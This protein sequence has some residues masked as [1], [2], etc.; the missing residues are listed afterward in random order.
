MKLIQKSCIDCHDEDVQ[1]GNIR[2]DNLAS[3]KN[4][5]HS[6][7]TWLDVYDKVS[8]GEMPPKKKAF[9]EEEKKAFLDILGPELSEFDKEKKN[10]DG[11]VVLRRLSAAEYENSIKDLLH[12][13]HLEVKPYLPADAEY[14]GIENVAERQ[15]IAYSHIAMYLKAAETSLQAAVGLRNKPKVRPR[16]FPGSKL[17]AA[18]KAFNNAYKAIGEKLILI[19]EP[20]LAQ[21]SWSLFRSPPE[22][23]FYKIRIKAHSAQ[24][25]QA[26]F[27]T[28]AKAKVLPGK[29]KQTV[30][31]GISLG[32]FLK[33]FDLH[34][35]SKVQEATVW[36]NGSERLSIQCEDLPLRI[37]KFTNG[38]KPG[39]WDAVA[40]DWV[41]IEGPIISQWPS[42]GHKT[43]FGDLP[44]K[45]WTPQS[46]LQRPRDIAIGTG[47]ERR[48]SSVNNHV[49]SKDPL[50]D[51]YPLLHSFMEKAYRRKVA[52]EEVKTMQKRVL[53]AIEQ[54]ICFH[55]AM[56]IAYKAI[57]CTPDFLYVR[58]S[59]GKLNS[60][61]LATRLSLFLWRSI[62]DKQL[63]ETARSG[64][65]E[66]QNTLMAEAK[67]MLDDP[68][69]DRF[70]NDFLNQW[71][72]MDSIYSTVPDK[73]LYPEYHEQNLLIE[74]LVEE[75]RLYFREM[76]KKNL[77]IKNVV[78]SDFSFLNDRLARHYKIPGV[79]GSKFRKVTL[80]ENSVRGGIIT[81]G[82]M[83]KITA[84]GFTTSPIKRGIWILENVLG[85]PPPPPPPNAGSIEPDT[86][87]AK[88]IREQLDKHRE[89]KS[90]ANCHKLIDPPGFALECFDIMGAFRKDYRSMKVGKKRIIDNGMVRYHI[91]LGLPV[92][93]SGEFSG[94]TFS[95]IHSFKKL[96]LKDTRQIARNLV[97]RLVT[98]STG[99]VP[100]FSDRKI[101]NKLLDASEKDGFKLKS[102]I[103]RVLTTPMFLEK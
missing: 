31:I 15:Q 28:S 56:L 44:I 43:L 36:L 32:R 13:P 12:I 16:R 99:A 78:D 35:E 64:K 96:L 77:S 57:L 50:T 58:E 9:S 45:K 30:A 54:K 5:P 55:D 10:S 41:E 52:D 26:G 22:P 100:T 60:N 83:M 11:R 82:S 70:I 39:I 94:E 40:I 98:Q 88:T 7:H 90:C 25:P 73:S 81:H 63:T 72:D 101:I 53:D 24:F 21:V 3:V 74:D 76:V 61:E 87:G 91:R 97:N 33:T 20:E 2:L 17:G 102:L 51:S 79:K 19:K 93:A 95:D 85:T 6:M 38:K 49:V 86:R 8:S 37:S 65:L 75:T 14:H 23:G 84:N 67:R 80:P 46:G 68:K 48:K 42:K 66:D 1:K 18:R 29:T 92:D 103:G 59:P 27:K 62:P 69:A 34:P 47:E 89:V 4:D 71:L